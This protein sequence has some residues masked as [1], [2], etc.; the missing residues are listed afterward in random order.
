MYLKESTE[1]Y[2]FELTPY[3]QSAQF[4]TEVDALTYLE[5]LN[6]KNGRK[7]YYILQ[8][9]PAF[10]DFWYQEGFTKFKNHEFRGLFLV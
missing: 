2:V 7:F 5:K 4:Y 9:V 3:K 8:G 10:R 1:T 6:S